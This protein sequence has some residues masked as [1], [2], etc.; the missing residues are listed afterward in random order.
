MCSGRGPTLEPSGGDRQ[1]EEG[2]K[3]APDSCIHAAHA[4]AGCVAES[5]FISAR[6]C[7]QR[8]DLPPLEP[9]ELVKCV[10]QALMCAIDNAKQPVIASAT[11]PCLQ[12]ATAPPKGPGIFD[13]SAVPGIS[14]DRYLQRLKAVFNCSESSFVLALIII[15]RLLEVC[16]RTGQDPQR[17]TMLNVHR[18]FLASLIVTVK[19]NEDLVYGNSHYAKAGGTQLREVNRLERFLLKALDYDFHVQPEQ[20]LFY[21]NALRRTWSISTKVTQAAVPVPLTAPVQPQVNR[22]FEP[23]PRGPVAEARST[24][25]GVKSNVGPQPTQ[26]VTLLERG[27]VTAESSLAKCRLM[28]CEVA[29]ERVAERLQDEASAIVRP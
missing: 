2:C 10:A 20:Y 16:S 4:R 28:K 29:V 26:A 3:D 23:E 6:A 11:A 19:F 8:D 15:D 1:I 21:I 13:S 24:P 22:K 17:I 9:H 27:A 7:Q 12:A 18:L 5:R 25:C 14:V